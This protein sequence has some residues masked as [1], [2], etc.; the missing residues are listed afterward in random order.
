M[1]T[2]ALTLALAVPPQSTLHGT[3]Q[4][5]LCRCGISCD[6]ADVTVSIKTKPVVAKTATTQTVKQLPAETRREYFY[7]GR[8]LMYRDVPVITFDSSALDC[9]SGTCRYVR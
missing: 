2:L 4:S 5:T 6:C 8:R 9:S 3:P 7:Q 1:F